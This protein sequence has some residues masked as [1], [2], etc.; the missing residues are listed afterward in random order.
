MLTMGCQLPRGY[1]TYGHIVWITTMLPSQ[2]LF[3]RPI[4]NSFVAR[5]SA[6]GAGRSA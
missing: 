2:I 3:G 6:V 5:A 4:P 1:L